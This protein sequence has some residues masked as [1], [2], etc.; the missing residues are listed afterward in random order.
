VTP[1]R[2]RHRALAPAYGVED[3][4]S[5]RAHGMKDDDILNPVQ[6]NGATKRR[7]RCSAA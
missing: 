5:C 6:G 1:R 4:N 2:H 3:F 7:C